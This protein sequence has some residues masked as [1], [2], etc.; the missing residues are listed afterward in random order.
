[1]SIQNLFY[2]A[3]FE[4]L[5]NFQQIPEIFSI[6]NDIREGL[7]HENNF[8]KNNESFILQKNE[9]ISYI[10]KVRFNNIVDIFKDEKDS[11]ALITL[12]NGKLLTELSPQE[13][14][15]NLNAE[16]P[17]LI[18]KGMHQVIKYSFPL[19]PDRIIMQDLFSNNMNVLV[20]YGL[21]KDNIKFE[22]ER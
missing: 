4:I 15:N 18:L 9:I 16:I 20:K 10:Q 17:R 22:S 19:A 2:K 13:L 5:Q 14:F 7:K 11:L 1:M 12:P 21:L 3:C 6:V 8:P